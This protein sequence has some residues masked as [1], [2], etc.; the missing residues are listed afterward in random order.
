MLVEEEFYRKDALFFLIIIDLHPGLQSWRNG[1]IFLSYLGA[2][3]IKLSI[4][5]MY[6]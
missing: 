1:T 2:F 4:L 6:L 5:C 3:Y